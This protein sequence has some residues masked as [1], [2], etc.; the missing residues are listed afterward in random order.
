MLII[1]LLL[2]LLKIGYNRFVKIKR[3]QLIKKLYLFFSYYYSR[4][5]YCFNNNK[6]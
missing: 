4:V 5:E 3:F 1:L 6:K 2:L